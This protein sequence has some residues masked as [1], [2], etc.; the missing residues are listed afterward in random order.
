MLNNKKLFKDKIIDV[1]LT[2]KVKNW[3]EKNSSNID[4]KNQPNTESDSQKPPI[5]VP[6]YDEPTFKRKLSK[7]SITLFRLE[8]E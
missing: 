3:L 6:N 7:K 5:V 1:S 2:I 4:V 8:K